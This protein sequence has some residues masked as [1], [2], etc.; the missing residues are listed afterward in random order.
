MNEWTLIFDSEI[1]QGLPIIWIQP[2]VTKDWKWQKERR[3]E[4]HVGKSIAQ[5]GSH[6]QDSKSSHYF[7]NQYHQRGLIL[8]ALIQHSATL[9]APD[10]IKVL[11]NV[12]EYYLNSSST[13]EKKKVTYIILSFPESFKWVKLN[14]EVFLWHCLLQKCTRYVLWSLSEW[15]NKSQML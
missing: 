12:C 14:S 13:G 1:M 8:I 6:N 2:I 15:G 11:L 10:T 3:K 7:T 4:D 9:Q 5:L